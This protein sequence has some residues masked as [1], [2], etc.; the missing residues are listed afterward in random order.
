MRSGIIFIIAVVVAIVVIGLVFYNKVAG[1]HQQEVVLAGA[2]NQA[3]G[4]H[5]CLPMF[6]HRLRA[7]HTNTEHNLC[8]LTAGKV[9]M[10]VNTASQCGYTGQ[11]EGLE[12]LHQQYQG[13]DFVILGFP[14][15]SFRQEHDSEEE[16]ATVC[17]VNYGVTFPM[18]A[19]S[20]VTGTDANPIFKELSAATKQAPAW[21]FHK[22]IV[23]ADGLKITSFPSK[24]E[25]LDNAITQVIHDY[26]E[27]AQ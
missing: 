27:E 22:Y 11:F 2:A 21:N 8:E 26:L 6:Q 7:L 16:T 13:Q 5:A 12:A 3:D 14:S 23:S 9:V 18:M 25:P 24:V 10:V 1:G 15:D 20:K 17:F 4:E 19:T